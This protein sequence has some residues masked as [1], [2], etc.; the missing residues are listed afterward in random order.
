M[1]VS[2]VTP[3]PASSGGWSGHGPYPAGAS[4]DAHHT[5]SEYHHYCALRG[6]AGA[7]AADA[8]TGSTLA[9]QAA[10]LAAA[11]GELLAENAALRVLAA[12]VTR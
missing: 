7:E 6:L 12:E 1:T 10:M 5:L 11:L 3:A 4:E 2:T 9:A 8:E